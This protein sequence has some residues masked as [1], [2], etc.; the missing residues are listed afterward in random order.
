MMWQQSLIKFATVECHWR[1][2][3]AFLPVYIVHLSQLLP[4][5]GGSDAADK[6]T[7]GYKLPYKRI[8]FWEIYFSSYFIMF[9]NNSQKAISFNMV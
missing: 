7:F 6:R 1:L 8:I 2:G 5:A 9:A 4:G 3:E